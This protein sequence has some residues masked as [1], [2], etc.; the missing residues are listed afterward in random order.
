MLWKHFPF[1]RRRGI[2]ASRKWIRKLARNKLSGVEKLGQRLAGI[3]CNSFAQGL[4]LVALNDLSNLSSMLFIQLI[5]YTYTL[6]C[7]FKVWKSSAELLPISSLYR[8]YN[9]I[10]FNWK[11]RDWETSIVYVTLLPLS[12]DLERDC[13]RTEILVN[14]FDISQ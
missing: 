6:Y 2:S 11:Q 1:I 12:I 4:R 14:A 3:N 8:E 7:F 10:N 13:L 9:S 5:A